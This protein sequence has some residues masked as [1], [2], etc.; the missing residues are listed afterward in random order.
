MRTIAVRA[1]RKLLRR[2]GCAEVR[3]SGSHL[4]VRCGTCQA[5]IPI[6]AGDVAPGT[7]RS[8]E[9]ALALCLGDEWLEVSR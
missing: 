6:H 4:L 5:T 8:I 2:L 9:H 1:L 3:Q 7:L